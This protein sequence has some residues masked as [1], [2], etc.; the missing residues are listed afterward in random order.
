MGSGWEKKKRGRRKDRLFINKLTEK[1]ELL[2]HSR[3]HTCFKACRI[4]VAFWLLAC[5][6]SNTIDDDWKLV[7]DGTCFSSFLILI[8]NSFVFCLCFVFFS[9]FSKGA[10]W[11]RVG[12]C[13]L[14]TLALF[15]SLSYPANLVQQ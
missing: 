1:K 9:F 3:E 8:S 13:R 12:T 5:R 15:V 11:R 4:L 6:D 2:R 10:K 7:F 14:Q